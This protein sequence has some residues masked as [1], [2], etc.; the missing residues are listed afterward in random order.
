MSEKKEKFFDDILKAREY[1]YL[2]M[3]TEALSHFDIGLEKIR[4]KMAKVPNDRTLQTEWKSINDE[5]QEEISQC[6]KLRH[7]IMSGRLDFKEPSRPAV[8]ERGN[9]PFT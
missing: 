8:D 7:T 3:Y 4:S 6:K 9:F 2:G 5:I 1:A